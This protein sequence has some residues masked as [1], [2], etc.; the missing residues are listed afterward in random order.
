MEDKDKQGTRNGSYSGSLGSSASLFVLL[1]AIL[2]LLRLR[3][4]DVISVRVRT[5]MGVLSPFMHRFCYR[6]SAEYTHYL[7]GSEGSTNKQQ[8]TGRGAGDS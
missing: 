8:S 2:L 6:L 5:F 1:A 7:F 3:N 4:F